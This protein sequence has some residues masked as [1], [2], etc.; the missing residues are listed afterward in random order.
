MITFGSIY[1]SDTVVSSG[2]LL[3]VIPTIHTQSKAKH[4]CKL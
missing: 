1:C 3:H 4:Y 2:F